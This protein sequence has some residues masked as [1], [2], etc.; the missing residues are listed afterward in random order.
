MPLTRMIK[1]FYKSFL[2]SLVILYLSLGNIHSPQT[3][4]LFNIPHLDKVVHFFLYGIL[5]YLLMYESKQLKRKR[6]YLLFVAICLLYGIII[7]LLQIN[8]AHRTG[9]IYDIIANGLGSITAVPLFKKFSSS[10][11]S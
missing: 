11:K 4:G 1:L 7:E 10:N 5:C 9:D 8:L 3:P 6:H 2:F